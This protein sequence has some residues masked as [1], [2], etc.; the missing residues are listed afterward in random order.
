LWIVG[1][2]IPPSIKN[3]TSDPNIIFDENNKDETEDIYKQAFL[4]L[5]PIRVGGGTS[6]KVLESM[7]TGT[8]VVTT[9]LGIEGLGAKNKEHVLS[10]ENSQETASNVLM[11]LNDK[12][13]YLKLTQNA[14]NFV[15]KN[16]SW[17]KIS[18]QLEIVYRKALNK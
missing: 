5:S 13:L 14:R 15:E 10:S 16:Y 4:L 12:N 2:N 8:A 1:K 17:E 7:A 3:L 6:Y 18:E 9:N 11:L